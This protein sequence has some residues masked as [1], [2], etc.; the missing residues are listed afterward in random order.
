M[1]FSGVGVSVYGTIGPVRASYVSPVSS[2]SVDGTTPVAYPASQSQY[3]QYNQ[4]FYQSPVLPSGQHS[5]I[6]TNTLNSDA[7]FLDYFIVQPESVTSTSVSPSSSSTGLPSTVG[8]G[9]SARTTAVVVGCI[10]GAVAGVAILLTFFFFWFRRQRR[11]EQ[12]KP[13]GADVV[14]SC[15]FPFPAFSAL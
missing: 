5:L 3:V 12:A 11:Q 6:V 8:G 14:S 4:R 7:L 9:D 1:L 13:S 15:E 10:V 2:Y